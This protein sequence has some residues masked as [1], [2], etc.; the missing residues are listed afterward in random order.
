MPDLF[1]C[2]KSVKKL[3]KRRFPDSV[4]RERCKFPPNL[5][6]CLNV[7]PYFQVK[8]INVYKHIDTKNIC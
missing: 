1:Y 3:F 4:E 6:N 8:D 7:V 2:Q 5:L